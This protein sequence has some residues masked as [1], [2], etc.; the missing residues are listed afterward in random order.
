MEEVRS[1]A[2]THLQSSI[3]PDPAEWDKEKHAHVDDDVASPRGV[4]HRSPTPKGS[5]DN[6]LR[7]GRP[8]QHQVPSQNHKKDHSQKHKKKPF[9][10]HPCMLIPVAAVVAFGAMF[11]IK[12]Q[13][14]EDTPEVSLAR[15]ANFGAACASHL[16]VEDSISLHPHSAAC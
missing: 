10:F 11:Y 3:G 15:V 2:P 16:R 14:K 9:K 8:R 6:L 12:S 7:H 13:K 1:P 5:H 4:V